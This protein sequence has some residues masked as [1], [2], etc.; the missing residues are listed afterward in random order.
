MAEFRLAEI[1][2]STSGRILEGDPSRRFDK[3]NIDSRMTQP[4]EM[5][6][7]IVARRNGHD[8]VPDAVRRGARGAV[9][10]QD[11]APPGEDV[12]LVRVDDTVEALQALARAA[13]AGRPVKVIGI[14]GSIGKTTTKEFTAS[15]LSLRYDVLKSEGNLNNHLG[16]AL[17][18]LKLLPIHQVAVLEMAMNSA[19]E[20][21][22]LTRIASPDIAVITNV[23]PVHLEFFQSVEDIALAK[24][25]ILEGTKSGG[26]AV[27]NGDDT[28][29]GDIA[30]DWK[31]RKITFGFSPG[32]DV[33]ASGVEK[34]GT[35][36]LSFAL[37]LEERREKVFFPFL[38]EDYI[39]NLLAAVG[40]SHAL[41][42]PLDAVVG[43]IPRLKPFE[44]RGILVPLSRGIRLV[45]DSYNSNPKA[46]AAAL[47]S[48]AGLPARRK[49]AVLGDMLELGERA[50]EFH[51]QAGKKAVEFGWDILVTVGPLARQMAEGARTAGMAEDRIL[52]FSSTEEAAAALAS[53]IEDGDLV[54]VKG[55]R[56][57]R[58]D[59]LVEKL[60]AEF[61]EN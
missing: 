59:R 48:L 42:V 17:S 16:L 39:Y 6:F 37:R 44:K 10:S 29:V 61:K 38:Y 28:L 60:K 45:D 49:V 31:G 2:A 52:S 53:I 25:E 47:R 24:K 34:M 36:G 54:L 19:G 22:A 55:S 57:V 15:L 9:I 27:L 4:G 56:G 40:V 32:C 20:V 18:L 46:L 23:N 8:Y 14:T 43:Q 58:T 41:S 5:F 35:D 1:A 50:P 12:A 26:A 21:R 13:L 11:I 3:F 33:Q 30:R 51:R 7:A